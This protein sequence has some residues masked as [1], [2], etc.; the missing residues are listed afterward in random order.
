M[1][2]DID[3]SPYLDYSRSTK[4]ALHGI[5]AAAASVIWAYKNLSTFVEQVSREFQE[6]IRK[7]ARTTWGD[8]ADTIFVAYDNSSGHLRIFS[9]DPRAQELEY[10]TPETPPRPILRNAANSAQT[11]FGERLSQVI[12]E[13]IN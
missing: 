7:K 1:S 11:T 12:H 6:D 2:S 8:V 4:A 10:G 3:L 9:L 13:A 5:P